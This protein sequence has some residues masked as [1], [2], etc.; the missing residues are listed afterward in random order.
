MTD[1]VGVIA[2]GV[3]FYAF[4][5]VFPAI[6]AALLVWGWFASDAATLHSHVEFFRGLAPDA[7]FEL[8]AEQMRRIAGQSRADIGI[9][10]IVTLLIG[11]WSSSR[12]VAAMMGALNMAYHERETR[13]FVHVNLLAA[14]FTLG[15]VAFVGVSIAAIAA[16]PPI[17]D[18]LL[19]GAFLDALLR[20][21]RWLV[22]IGL[23][24]VAGCVVYRY[25]PSRAKARWRWIAP[26]ALLAASVW[27]IASVAFSV[28]LARFDAY[29]AAFGSLGAVA[30]LLMWFWISAWALCIGAELNAQLE[31]YTT[32][33]T[34]IGP[35]APPGERDAFVADHVVTSDETDVTKP[36]TLEP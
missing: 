25:G 16:V 13:G 19:L 21:V 14:G 18:A 31:L 11:L 7:A 30:A 5:S 36:Q 26:G 12:G 27:L 32:R 33:D 17:L 4:L 8:I 3:A 22:M 34:T 6:A 20:A 9:G 15:G 1:N 29:A 24:F 23:F 10:L 28:Y 35:A 2:G